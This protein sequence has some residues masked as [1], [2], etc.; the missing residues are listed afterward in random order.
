MIFTSPL[1]SVKDT[2]QCPP[3]LMILRLSKSRSGH[4]VRGTKVGSRIRVDGDMD[5]EVQ[6]LVQIPRVPFNR[7]KRYNRGRRS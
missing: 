3:V 4:L 6:G 5:H 2:T 1:P 7:T